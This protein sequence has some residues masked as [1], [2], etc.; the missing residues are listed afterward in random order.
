MLKP[1]DS[2]PDFA[3]PVLNG[4]LW[5]LKTALKSA[6]LVLVFFK[7]SCETCHLTL[8]LMQRLADA[9]V[10]VIAISQDDETGTR[11]F[12]AEFGISLP[13]LLDTPGS[14]P[15]SNAYGIEI[16]P[17][18]CVIEPGLLI[19]QSLIGFVHEDFRRL[20]ASF[21]LPGLLEGAS[22]PAFK[23]GCMGKN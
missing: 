1:G 12:H 19:N 2:A 23:P 11:E 10:P 3:L 17:T 18:V 7:I 4:G 8:P 5:S 21:G 6:P 14:W 13:T 20:A 15:V 16:V 22:L 9:G